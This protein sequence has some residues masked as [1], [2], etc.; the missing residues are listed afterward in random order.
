MNNCVPLF[1]FGKMEKILVGWG[2]TLSVDR[3]VGTIVECHH[4]LEW[5]RTRKFWALQTTDGQK[6]HSQVFG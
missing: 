2:V 5:K 4:R 6:K 3:N 1:R